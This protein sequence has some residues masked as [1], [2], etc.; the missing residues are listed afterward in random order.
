MDG[1]NYKLID[2]QK[3][4]LIK[5]SKYVFRCKCIALIQHQTKDKSGMKFSI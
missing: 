4:G 5:I 2:F 1:E 3:R